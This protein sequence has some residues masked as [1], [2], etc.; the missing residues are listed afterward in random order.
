[1]ADNPVAEWFLRNRPP[2][3]GPGKI[4]EIDEAMFGKRKYNKGAYRRGCGCSAEW[5]ER[6]GSASWRPRNVRSA[7]VILPFIPRW[8]L[9]G[10]IIYS[11]EWAAYNGL[12]SDATKLY[13]RECE[14]FGPVCRLTGVH[15]NTQE[16]LWHHVKRQM[17]GSK[18]LEAVLLDFMFRRR[19]NASAD[20]FNCYLTVLGAIWVI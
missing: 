12:T 3:G 7:H 5:I 13:A 9:P 17:K 18:D 2:I 15:T 4:V 11:D 20:A 14:P 6:L 10:T 16:G 19:F 8:V 1:M